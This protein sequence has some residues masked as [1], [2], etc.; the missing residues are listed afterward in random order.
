M[1][2]G[3]RTLQNGFTDQPEGWNDEVLERSKKPVGAG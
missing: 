1:T 3:S 2:T